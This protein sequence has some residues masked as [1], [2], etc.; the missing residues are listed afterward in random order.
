MRHNIIYI[1]GLILTILYSE[2]AA[3]LPANPWLYQSAEAQ[4]S[5]SPSAAD[6]S[7]VDL[8]KLINE[9]LQNPQNQL[10][11]V[12]NE[13]LPE[14]KRQPSAVLQTNLPSWQ[15]LIGQINF[16]AIL[17]K[18]SINRSVPK[19]THTSSEQYKSN[20][21]SDFRQQYQKAVNTSN[22]YYKKAKRNLKVL[23]KEAQSS[24]DDLQRKIK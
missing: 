8:V 3:A 10:I 14:Q 2:T 12:I 9:Q 13:A 16:Q 6:F 22:A 23:E 19:S 11:Q 4:S 1:F 18:V 5:D 7:Q 21:V 15:D 20:A 17:P 24:I